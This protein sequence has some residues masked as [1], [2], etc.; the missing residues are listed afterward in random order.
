MTEKNGIFEI[1]GKRFIQDP[2]GALVPEE[3]VKQIDLLRDQTVR[4]VVE[5]IEA[6]QQ[7]M[8]E[9][10]EACLADIEEFVTIAADDHGVKLGGV[11]GNTTLT[12][13]DGVHR[14]TLAVSD[15]LDLNEG[16]HAAKQ[17]IDEYLEDITKDSSADLRTL[18]TRAFRVKQ[19]KMDV[20]RILELRSYNI[21]DP[22]WKKAMEIISES[23][24]IS[25]SRKHFRVHQR[26]GDMY[27]QMDLDFST[28]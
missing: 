6:M 14:I 23:L 9:T 19:G 2:R 18:V 13:F 22:R 24:R 10:K 5:R 1:R 25:S 21:A 11:R 15:A 4:S 27:Q 8:K 16:V 12:S 20:K 3:S 28:I 7:M 26:K 17:L